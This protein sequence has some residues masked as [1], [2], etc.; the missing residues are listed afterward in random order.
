MTLQ[1]EQGIIPAHAVSVIGDADQGA[2]SS[3]DLN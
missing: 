1:T 2:A 3:A